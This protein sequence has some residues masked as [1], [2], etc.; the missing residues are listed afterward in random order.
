VEEARRWIVVAIAVLGIILLVG[1]AR[2]GP[3]VGG[4]QPDPPIVIINTPTT[5]P[6]SPREPTPTTAG[7]DPPSGDS[8]PSEPAATTSG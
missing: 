7:S 1:L 5:N 3:G 2:N 6:S 8:R 4:R